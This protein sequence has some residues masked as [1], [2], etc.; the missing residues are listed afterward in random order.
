MLISKA[1]WGAPEL[2]HE[3]DV[4]ERHGHRY[5]RAYGWVMDILPYLAGPPHRKSTEAARAA[6][7]GVSGSPIAAVSGFPAVK[8]R[9]GSREFRVERRMAGH[10]Y[11][12]LPLFLGV[13][14]GG[15]RF[16]S[17]PMLPVRITRAYSPAERCRQGEAPGGWTDHGALATG[18]SVPPT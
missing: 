18:Q 13:F 8:F 1:N 4:W 3:P 7:T 6:H 10:C 16:F 17:A 12:C 11:R 14:V 15:R 9:V 5:G 2:E